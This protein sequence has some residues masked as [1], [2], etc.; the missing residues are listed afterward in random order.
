MRLLWA[1]S[2]LFFCVAL[3]AAASAV[4]SQTPHADSS[5][6]EYPMTT[7]NRIQSSG[8]WPTKGTAPREDFVGE[9]L[10]AKCHSNEAASWAATPMAHA[11]M[12][13]QDSSILQQFQ[14][15]TSQ[16]GPYRYKIF[17]AGDK[18]NF[19]VGRDEFHHGTSDLGLR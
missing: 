19:S 9:A 10:C 4:F 2:F 8:W 18:W 14:D 1:K 15:L 11:S 13:A 6:T 5:A 12:L 7:E 3:L 16:S 17:K